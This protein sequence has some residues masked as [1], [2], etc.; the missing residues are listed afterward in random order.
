MPAALPDEL[1]EEIF[2]RLPPD[3][4]AWLVRASLASKLWLGLLSGPSFRRRYRDLHG[5]PPMLGFLYSLRFFSDDE[6]EEER[7]P[8]LVPTTTRFRS[9]VPGGGWRPWRYAPLDCRHGRA[10]LE[11]ENVIPGL[12]V[13]WDPMTGRQRELDKP[14]KYTTGRNHRAAVLCAATGSNH[15]ACHDGP[16]LVVLVGLRGSRA[17]ASVFSSETGEWSEPCSKLALGDEAFVEPMPPV[18]I[19]DALFFMFAYDEAENLGNIKYDLGSN[20][21]SLI[22]MPVVGYVPVGE[23]M[24]MAKDDGSLGFAYMEG[25]TLGLWSRQMGSDGVASWTNEPRIVSL[26]NLLPTQNLMETL[27]LNGS[28]E[29]S[30]IIFVATSLGALASAQCKKLWK[31][32]EYFRSLFP[33]MSFYNPQ[34]R[35]RPCNVAHL[36]EK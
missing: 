10:L 35:A 28:V 11:I 12:L 29:G 34:E 18:L 2:L 19:G 32:E 25:L 20:R 9:R 15:E 31:K 36:P 23:V 22:D 4:P 5:A 3:E 7:A 14:R 1:L 21:L 33:Y 16:F 17:R 6:K 27:E 8:N 13:V 30:D 24:L 26:K